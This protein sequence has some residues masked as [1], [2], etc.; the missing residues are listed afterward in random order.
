[1]DRLTQ[2][3]FR[4][5]LEFL[6]GAY[7]LRDLDGFVRYLITS[8]SGLVPSDATVYNEYNFKRNRIIWQ[9]NPAVAFAGSEK[10]WE[11]YSH[12]HPILTHIRRTK[13]G[14]AVK[15]SDFISERQFRRTGLY[16]E[17]FRPL[18]L[19]HQM[20]ALF[21]EP[22]NL[23]AGLA[24]NREAK[25]FSERE[26]LLMNLLRPHLARSYENA[27]A[28]TGLFLK[29]TEIKTALDRLDRGIVFLT[30]GR[31]IKD[32][33]DPARRLLKEFFPARSA[34]GDR[35][36][37]EL[38]TWLAQEKKAFGEKDRVPAPQKSLVVRRQG[39]QLRV[40]WISEPGQT[41]ILLEPLRAL[42][43]GAFEALGLT[44]RE[45]EVLFWMTQGKTNPEIAILIGMGRRTVEKHTERIFE[46]LGVETRTAAAARAMDMLRE[47]FA[48][49]LA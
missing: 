26:R 34:P 27:E 44:R 29:L 17:F 48:E 45:A 30:R 4:A 20:H 11:R 2:R 24:L 8:L 23:L 47:R 9:Q 25:D 5:L 7:A 46:K 13:D 32:M 12:E 49:N 3:D 41:L 35:I 39:K 1:V 31:R 19:K 14:R 40:R 16:N 22:Q 6:Q 15:F 38:A 10:I 42:D 43:P 36:P 33:T 21:G 37:E 28:I 18:R